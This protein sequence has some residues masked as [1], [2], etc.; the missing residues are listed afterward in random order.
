M[1]KKPKQTGQ[2]FELKGSLH[3]LTT[4]IFNDIN[5]DDIQEQLKKIQKKAP[6]FFNQTP[7]IIDLG[8]LKIENT[9]NNI[10]TLTDICV[11]LRNNKMIPIG[12]QQNTHDDKALASA[13][14]LSQINTKPTIDLIQPT[15]NDPKSDE[16]KTQNKTNN[17]LINHPVRSGQQL[18]AKQGDLIL[19][20]TSSAGSELI[21]DHN[22]HIYGALRGKAIAGVQGNKQAQIFCQK[23]QAELISIAG[24]YCLQ[25]DFP[26]KLVGSPT[27]IALKEEALVFEPL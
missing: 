11:L 15:N 8:Y 20:G 19:V 27:R 7:I 22:I 4:L 3:T 1:S 10:R 2:A 21:A 26:S 17:K 14:E 24:V 9:P 18:Y 5:V 25:E 23:L 12:L 13:L 16:S 6:N